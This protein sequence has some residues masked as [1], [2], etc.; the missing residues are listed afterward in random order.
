MNVRLMLVQP[1][2]SDIHGS[3][4]RI[5]RN[6]AFVPPIGI[7]MLAS[8]ARDAGFSVAILDAEVAGLSD[9]DVVERI[10][11]EKPTVVG[12]SA[13]TPIYH[14]AR[15][16]A[17][18]LKRQQPDIRTIIG[19]PHISLLGAEA[20]FDCFDLA[21]LGE[22]E[23][24]FA[25][26]LR[27]LAREDGSVATIPGVMYRQ[28]GQIVDNGWGPTPHEL[29]ALPFPAWDLLE[30]RYRT[31]VPDKGYVRYATLLYTRGCP[32]KCSFC[33]AMLLEGRTLRCR[34]PQNVV[35]EMQMLQER[36]DIHHFCFNDSTLTLR[37]RNVVELAELL[38][39]KGMKVTWEGWTRA[40][41]IDMEL[42]TLMKRAGMVRIS[43][44]IESGSPRV[45]KLIRKEVSHDEMRKAFRMAKDVG[46]EVT[47][48]A[49][50]G[51]PGE[52]EAD[53][54]ETVR[55]IRSIPEIS[56]SPLSIAVPYPGTELMEMAKEGR[57]GLKLVTTDYS[58]YS[59]Y[60]GGVM[61]VNG[62][63]PEY[64]SRLQKRALIWM[65]LTPNKFIG[66]IKR[67]GFLALLETI[68]PFRKK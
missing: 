40:N 57:H 53:V 28:G 65:H 50:M 13:T 31:Q 56:Y 29:D 15:L 24:M 42:L 36:F 23:L 10:L 61:E 45:L 9:V 16:I 47:C 5:A 60:E 1:A 2:W 8:I 22:A 48:S 43:F 35:A 14:K 58:K 30:D 59:R 34:S 51:H 21:V 39:E 63:S 46:M 55:L 62:M 18:G 44:G 41:L 64:L 3:F 20:F 54:W 38:L 32:F 12:L 4:S 67:F 19:G 26:L 25:D 11:R 66:I 68:L 6:Q 27:G 49:M 37:K 33:A 17:E 7:T 52:T